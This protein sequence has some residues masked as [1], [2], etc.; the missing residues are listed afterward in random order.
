MGIIDRLLMI[1]KSIVCIKSDVFIS[2][3]SPCLLE[4]T[5]ETILFVNEVGAFTNRNTIPF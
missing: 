1:C 3:L 5:F 4:K 2:N